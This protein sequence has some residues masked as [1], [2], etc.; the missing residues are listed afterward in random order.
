MVGGL[1]DD[2]RLKYRESLEGFDVLPKPYS[3]SE[4][5]QKVKD[6]LAKPRGEI[7]ESP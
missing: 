7:K 6:V 2:Q 1:L 5:L 4:L 3:P